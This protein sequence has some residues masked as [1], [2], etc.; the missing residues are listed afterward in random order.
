MY[1]M[2]QELGEHMAKKAKTAVGT[3]TYL[4]AD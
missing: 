1:I 3:A 2:N 4:K